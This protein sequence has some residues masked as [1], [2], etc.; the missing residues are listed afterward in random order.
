MMTSKEMEARSG[1]AR[2]N[3][4]YY[5]AE[6]LLHPNRAENGYR[7]YSEADLVVLEKIK[8]LR[9]LGVT[10]EE[11]KALTSGGAALSAVLDRRLAE[12]GGE[13][14]TLGRVEQVCGDLRTAGETFSALEPGKYLEALD[15]PAL[16]SEDREAWWSQTRPAPLPESDA[17]PIC[18]SIP[19][20]FFA[21]AFDELLVMMLLMAAM[22]LTGHNPALAS[23]TLLGLAAQGLLLFAEPLLLHLSGTTPGKALL[24]L[25]LTG[26]HGQKLTY[27]E[28][29]TRHLLLLWYGL[30]L[31]IPIWNLVRLYQCVK[32]CVE[33]EPQPWDEEI[34]YT[35]AEFRLRRGAGYLLAACGVL[36]AA[37]TVNS[38]AQLPP[39]RGDLTVAEFAENFNRQAAYMG[40]EFTGQQ[41]N[42]HG[43]WEDKPFDGT[44]YANF[45]VWDAANLPF[46][47]TVEDGRVTAVTIS[48]E[49]GNVDGW[50]DLPVEQAVTSVTALLWA[51]EETPFWSF[52]R[53]GQAE[54]L[55]AA[56]WENCFLKLPGGSVTSH[57][58]ME[59][60]VLSDSL[61]IAVPEDDSGQKHLAVSITVALDD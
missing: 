37:E 2:A 10:I 31:G 20:R 30:G 35:A 32:R 43:D 41:L 34:A 3:I 49:A 27:G 26:P 16:P 14:E 44:A 59:G 5:E 6:G 1:V 15:A 23:G 36:L 40:M 38:Y 56:D 8:L 33:G 22:D 29:F 50:L 46:T 19:R 54:A 45:S 21:R 51:G 24:G 57:V 18:T 4:R 12:L 7:D 39:N 9:R 25:R 60:Y 13:R 58:E 28:A 53:K 61:H 11:L 55:S 48:G 42:E 17:L 52:A 47:Y